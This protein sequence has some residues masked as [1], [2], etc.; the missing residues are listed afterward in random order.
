MKKYIP[1]KYIPLLIEIKNILRGG[2]K[3]TYYS[4]F[5]EDVVLGK[6]FRKTNGFYVDVGAYHP[7]QYSNTYLLHKKKNWHGINIDPNTYS[8]QLFDRYRPNDINLN[9]GVAPEASEKDLYM[10]SHANWNTFSKEKA[11]EW[12]KKDGVRYLGEK[13]MSSL[14]LKDILD[15]HMKDG[16]KIDL[17]NVDAE[18]YDLQ[19]LQSND[20]SRYAPE[21]IVVESPEFDY[22]RPSE[23]AVHTFLSERSYRLYTQLGLSLIFIK[24]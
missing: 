15:Q 12:K 10:F 9:M 1:N 13:R 20:W 3:K 11:Q 23:N 7:K 19:V 6:L 16:Q 22:M 4:Q 17:L 8:I 18:G 14:P 21:V 5:G 2:Y 24:T